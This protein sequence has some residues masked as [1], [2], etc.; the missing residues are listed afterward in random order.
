MYSN[1]LRSD[2]DTYKHDLAQSTGPGAY[3]LDIPKINCD[4]CFLADPTIRMGHGG[5][6]TGGSCPAASLTDIDSELL[7][8]TRR[9]S[10]CPTKHYLP[11]GNP[12]CRIK[13]VRDCKALST[14]D[15]R[16]SNPPCTLRGGNNGFNR[17]EW[18]CGNPQAKAINLLPLNI[19]NRL[20]TKDAH[21][22]CIPRPFSAALALPP[23]DNSTYAYVSDN[24]QADTLVPHMTWQSCANIRRA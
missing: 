17:W 12:P 19:N 5:A 2:Q 20:L 13:N 22:P 11:T 16:L 1:R 23:E 3:L 21:R 4:N 8:I 14:E 7:G 15:T 18:L 10:R 24:I 9:S 6:T